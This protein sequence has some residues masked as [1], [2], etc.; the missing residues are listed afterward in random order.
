MKHSILVT[1]YLGMTVS[2]LLAALNLHSIQNESSK[3]SGIPVAVFTIVVSTNSSNRS[4]DGQREI[5][6][7]IDAPPTPMQADNGAIQ[8]GSSQSKQLTTAPQEQVKAIPVSSQVPGQTVNPDKNPVSQSKKV[9]LTGVACRSRSTEIFGLANYTF[10]TDPS[11]SPLRNCSKK[12]TCQ[13]IQYGPK[14]FAPPKDAIPLAIFYAGSLRTFVEL[15]DQHKKLLEIA[16]GH[17]AVV[18]M[19]TWSAVDYP[20]TGAQIL[21]RVPIYAGGVREKLDKVFSGSPVPLRVRVEDMHTMLQ[22]EN[23]VNML[24]SKIWEVAMAPVLKYAMCVSFDI[25]QREYLAAY[26]EELP[27]NAPV[28]RVRP[29]AHFDPFKKDSIVEAIKYVHANPNTEFT[30]YP[31]AFFPPREEVYGINSDA[32]YVTSAKVMRSFCAIDLE[33]FNSRL[34]NATQNDKPT[35]WKEVGRAEHSQFKLKSIAGVKD[36]F[37]LEDSDLVLK[38][39]DGREFRYKSPEYCLTLRAIKTAS[40]ARNWL[41]HSSLY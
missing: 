2:L 21:P 25:S 8:S 41:F 10:M 4:S 11:F 7:D 3:S 12:K 28:I 16:E 9:D 36:L 17:K 6:K 40:A 35:Y 30:V 18:T 23:R 29:D 33:Y 27:D 20:V 24:G 38:R 37:I 31:S 32:F 14:S 26:G 13:D 19:H 34:S 15:Q 39:V 1:V 22:V 5:Q